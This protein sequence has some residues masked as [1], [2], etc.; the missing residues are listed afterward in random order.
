MQPRVSVLIAVYNA[1]STIEVAVRSILRQTLTDFEL[2][3]VDD[4]SADA[5]P[6]I[7]SALAVGDAR[8][9]VVR[10]SHRGLIEALN[11]GLGLCRAE[12]IARMD[13]DDISHRDRL[14]EQVRLL[15][16]DP[17][18]S[19]CSS[20]V[21]MFPRNRLLGG[22]VRYERWLNSLIYPE[23]I[24]RDMFV[25]SPVAHPSVM[26]RRQELVDVGGYQEHGWPEDYDLWLRYHEAGK[27]FAKV[28][29]TLL[30]WR[31]AEGRVTLTDSRCSL[32]NFLRVKAHYLARAL[33][34]GGGPVVLWGA[35]KTG[36]RMLKHLIREGLDIRAVV[37]ID[38]AKIGHSLRGR[39]IVDPEWLRGKRVFVI[40][41]V[42][43]YGARQLI[44]ERLASMGFAEMRDFLCAA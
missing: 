10:R 6:H 17:T 39:P 2:V 21:R 32:E 18:I 5:T 8:V 19:V 38:P 13:A 12:L 37:D 7:L 44:R 26:M 23:E 4:G 25:E 14:L 15:E 22:M 42:S 36:R 30:F 31:H 29:K 20:L 41:A 27:R 28:P 3:V 34:A 11:C 33:D 9:R 24:A 43:S 1:A 40:A 35:G 16:S